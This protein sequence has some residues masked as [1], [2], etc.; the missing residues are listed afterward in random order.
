MRP[1]Y[2]NASKFMA[3]RN[4]HR[5][6]IM[7]LERA[8]P[9]LNVHV[10]N[11]TRTMRSAPRFGW[12]TA[13]YFNAKPRRGIKSWIKRHKG[14]VALH[15]AMFAVPL[16]AD[17]TMFGIQESNASARDRAFLSKHNPPMSNVL[18]GKVDYKNYNHK[19]SNNF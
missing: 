8:P 7:R 3:M 18:S 10:K 4:M 14:I 15:G 11:P 12:R 6:R 17:S 16:V 5:L 1:I 13:T 2:L 9:P 19:K